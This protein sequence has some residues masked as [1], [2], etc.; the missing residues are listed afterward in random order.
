MNLFTLSLVADF[1]KR[2]D[3]FSSDDTHYINSARLDFRSNE[4]ISDV[5]VL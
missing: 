3:M 5:Y 2:S 4:V 1:V